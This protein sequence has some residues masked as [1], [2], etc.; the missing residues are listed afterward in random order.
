MMASFLPPP[1]HCL[2][3]KRR[4]NLKTRKTQFANNKTILRLSVLTT[5]M[6]T[7]IHVCIL[8]AASKGVNFSAYM[9]F[10]LLGCG[11]FVGM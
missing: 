8:V 2:A 10:L 9:R 1:P 3:E 5:H 4:L 6:P 11:G 7:H